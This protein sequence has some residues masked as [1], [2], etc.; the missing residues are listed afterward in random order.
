MGLRNCKWH[1]CGGEF[2]PQSGSQKYCCDSHRIKMAEW[3]KMRGARLVTLLL[4]TPAAELASTMRL[5][6]K[7]LIDEVNNGS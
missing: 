6:R 2:S 4:E 3:K 5:E 1:R 7:A